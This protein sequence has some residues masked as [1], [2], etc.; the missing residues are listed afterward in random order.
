M[1]DTVISLLEVDEDNVKIQVEFPALLD[2]L[3]KRTLVIRDRTILSE[4]SL[5]FSKQ[6]VDKPS[7]MDLVHLQ[8]KLFSRQ[9]FLF[10]PNHSNYPTTEANQ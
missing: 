2:D 5:I 9:I 10:P 7:E 8:S 1:L 3:L 6:T 4:P